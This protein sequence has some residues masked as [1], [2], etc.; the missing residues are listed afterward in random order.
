MC[1]ED[2][3]KAVVVEDPFDIDSVAIVTT[4]T[5]RK[6]KSEKLRELFE[7]EGVEFGDFGQKFPLEGGTS[8]MSPSAKRKAPRMSP[9]SSSPRKKIKGKKKVIEL[10]AGNV[11]DALMRKLAPAAGRSSSSRLSAAAVLEGG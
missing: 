4:A 9:I 8:I 2:A 6:V 5:G 3:G 10:A 7:V 11:S 1:F